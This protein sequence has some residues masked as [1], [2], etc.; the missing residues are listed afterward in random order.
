MKAFKGLKELHDTLSGIKKN[1]LWEQLPESGR[2]QT[3]SS[4]K[5]SPLFKAILET[6]TD[7]I[8]AVDHQRKIIA[9]NRVFMDLWGIPDEILEMVEDSMLRDFVLK[10]IENP[11]SFQERV[12]YIY[13]TGEVS[14]DIIKLKDGK[15]LERC[16]RPLFQEKKMQGRIWIFRDI[17]ARELYEKQL[18]YFSLH[19]ALTGLYNRAFFEEEMKRMIESRE[20]P[21]TCISVDVDGLKFVNDALGHEHGDK[22]LKACSTVLKGALRRSD[23]LARIGGDE[24]V[25]LLPRTGRLTGEQIIQRIRRRLE[26]H[27]RSSFL[28]LSIS[29]GIST[30]ENQDSELE[31]A[32]NEADHHMYREKYQKSDRLRKQLME[33]IISLLEKKDF[34]DRDHGWRIYQWMYQAGLKL[35]FST[36]RLEKLGMLAFFHDLGKIALPDGILFKKESL[37]E[38]E[39]DLILQHPERGYRIAR[40]FNRLREIADLILKHHENWDGSGYPLGLKQEEIPLECRLLSIAEAYDVMTGSRPY[41]RS[42]SREEALEEL[43]AGAGSRFDPRLLQ[44]FMEILEDSKK[45]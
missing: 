38:N 3:D 21:L 20:Y 29:M 30:L 19:D 1:T 40:Q 31:K 34:L 15:I 45:V 8:L 7:G 43:W 25:V 14:Y 26:K 9:A 35:G 5:Q 28:P 33:K 6:L 12:N 22:H 37:K 42:R 18:K 2:E 44:V 41:C 24:F 11:G 39:W 4:D 32:I 17:T 13:R 23:I 36:N 27:N 10:K 16:S